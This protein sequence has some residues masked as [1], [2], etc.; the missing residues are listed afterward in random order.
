MAELSFRVDID[1]KGFA[2]V[3]KLSGDFKKAD[4]SA[5]K[6]SKALKASA[7]VAGAFALASGGAALA[8]GSIV[9]KTLEQIDATTKASRAV[10]VQTELYTG[11]IHVAK[12][13]GIEQEKLNGALKR[14]ARNM[15]DAEKGIGTGKVAFEQLG[16]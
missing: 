4:S 10:G 14:F 15:N 13:G 16:I 7:K 1:G 2:K 9:K 3:N 11:L 5:Q 8:V 6:F 12:L